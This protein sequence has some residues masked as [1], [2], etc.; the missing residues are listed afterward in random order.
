M[1]RSNELKARDI[2]RI[3]AY[4]DGELSARDMNRLEARFKEE[5]DL[6]RALKEL[7]AT[8][9]LLSSLPEMHPPRN[10]TL[11]PEMAGTRGRLNL[12]PVFRFVTVI[13]T[14]ALAVLVGTD[15]LLGR[16]GN[17]YSAESEAIDVLALQAEKAVEEEPPVEMPEAFE[18]VGP[19]T[20]GAQET[21]VAEAP[22]AASDNALETYGPDMEE[23]LM[24]GEGFHS[25]TQTAPTPSEPTQ[26][27]TSIP[28]PTATSSWVA[29]QPRAPS[30]LEP[31]Q[32]AEIALGL[33][34]IILIGITL[35]LRRTR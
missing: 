29:E 35:F 24:E 23:S 3:S 4:L 18:G 7:E 10:F 27:P 13:A 1:R 2:E 8:R 6:H 12:Y 20:G 14:V 26:I 28:H 32:I 25:L 17:L 34:A 9:D 31:I 19:E 5:P 30:A 33:S 22:R 15:I 16:V 21:V 11:T